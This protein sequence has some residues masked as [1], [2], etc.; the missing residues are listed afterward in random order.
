MCIIIIIIIVRVHR[1]IVTIVDRSLLDLIII[2][3]RDTFPVRLPPRPRLPRHRVTIIIVITVVIPV[4]LRRRLLGVRRRTRRSLEVRHRRARDREPITIIISS[5]RNSDDRRPWRNSFS[6]HRNRS[7]P[8]RQGRIPFPP[9]ISFLFKRRTT[10]LPR[11]PCLLHSVRF[12]NRIPSIPTLSPASLP[13]RHRFPLNHSNA[14]SKKSPRTCRHPVD[15]RSMTFNCIFQQRTRRPSMEKHRS[16]SVHR[17][18]FPPIN[19]RVVV[20]DQLASLASLISRLRPPSPRLVPRRTSLSMLS[21]TTFK[22]RRISIVYRRLGVNRNDTIEKWWNA[23]VQRANTIVPAVSKRVAPNVWIECYW[24]NVD[25]CVRA[26]NGAP[27]VDSS[28]VPT[29]VTN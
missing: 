9:R 20:F 21:W 7:N 17:K 11:C 4:E 28:V 27:I 1:D 19:V 12:R 2:I 8:S 22:S 14:S 23:N 15:R 24:S 29:P 26:D 5:R 18:T 6:K 10:M 13:H 16:K 25:R 3:D